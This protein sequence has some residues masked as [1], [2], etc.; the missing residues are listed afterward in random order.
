[1]ESKLTVIPVLAGPT[2]SGKTSLALRLAKNL[3]IEIISADAMLVYKGMDIGTAKPTRVEQNKVKH[4]LID[5]IT[6]DQTF[7]VAN[8]VK[9]AEQAI[10]EIL[11]RGKIPL[12]VGGTGFYIRALSQGLPSVPTANGEVQNTLWKRF[13]KEGLV[14]LEKE[15]IAFSPTDAKRAQ[16]N[17]RRIIRALEIIQRTGKAPCDFPFSKPAFTYKKV[18]LM[19][20]IDFLKEAIAKRTENMFAE[21][22]V[23]E[24][25][26]LLENYPK[27]PTAMQAI[28]Y[29]EVAAYLD[30]KQ[31]LKEAKGAINLATLQY[32]KRQR[33]WFRKEP[34]VELFSSVS[35]VTPAISAFAAGKQLIHY[36]TGMHQNR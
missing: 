18:V 5:V 28:G 1:M 27:R 2:T 9:L 20:E 33:T 11:A 15:L 22:F 24:V 21:G 3:D 10:A 6:P 17:P 32:A 8:Y 34:N 23:D 19:L 4:H 14:P 13:E 25:K 30:G 26:S 7:S 29:K 16:S 36:Q 12:V 35:E 31:T